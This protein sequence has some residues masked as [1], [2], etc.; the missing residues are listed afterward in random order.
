MFGKLKNNKGFSFIE[1]VVA[2]ALIALMATIVVP[3]FGSRNFKAE[4]DKLISK[5]DT[6]LLLGYQNALSTGK[7]HRVYIDLEKKLIRLEVDSG[8][9][10]SQKVAE[11]K[12]VDIPYVRSDIKFENFEIINLYINKNDKLSGRGVTKQTW[13]FISP[14]GLTQEVILNMKYTKNPE[15]T[16]ANF[17][18]ILNP[19]TAQFKTYDE[20]QKP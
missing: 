12:G 14:S 18:L 2:I 5:L 1:I 8:K 20:F 3:R 10:N 6:T 19:F 7:L 17:A 13:F 15:N 9:T 4:R 16:N 11:F